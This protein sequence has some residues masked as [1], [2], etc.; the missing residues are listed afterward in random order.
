[1]SRTIWYSFTA[2]T[3]ASL[4]EQLTKEN[5]SRLVGIYQRS[6]R[7]LTGHYTYDTMPI[8]DEV[9]IY[10]ALLQKEVVEV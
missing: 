8:Y 6:E 4:A 10:E 7:R 3:I 1:M 9:N 2:S 5:P